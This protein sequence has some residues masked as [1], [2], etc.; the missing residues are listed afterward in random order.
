MYNWCFLEEIIIET[1]SVQLFEVVVLSNLK[2]NV[3]KVMGQ[4]DCVAQIHPDVY[5]DN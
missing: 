3:K 2:T 1:I 5:V 4:H